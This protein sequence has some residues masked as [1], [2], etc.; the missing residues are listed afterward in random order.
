[1]HVSPKSGEPESTEKNINILSWRHA[2]H[3]TQRQ[4]VASEQSA[5]QSSHQQ[6]LYRLRLPIAHRSTCNPKQNGTATGNDQ[7]YWSDKIITLNIC[8]SIWVSLRAE[9]RSNHGTIVS[10]VNDI[11]NAPYYA[12]AHHT[13]RNWGLFSR[14][15]SGRGVI[16][17]THFNFQ[18]TADTKNTRRC[19]SIA[20][21]IIMTPV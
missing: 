12:A 2:R 7:C 15:H 17:T 4:P 9:Q 8:I 14:R 21:D 20:P 19:T 10:R 1:M 11:Y 5:G 13:M 16:L 6:S 3:Q 18:S